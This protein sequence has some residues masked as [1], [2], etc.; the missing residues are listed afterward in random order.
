MAAASDAC[1]LQRMLSVG[2]RRQNI[3]SDACKSNCM[4]E[5][6]HAGSHRRSNV[7]VPDRLIGHSHSIRLGPTFSS[8][9][10]SAARCYG[11]R[12]LASF[13]W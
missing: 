3:A 10:T 4:S 7:L 13:R 9:S 2:K 5:C 11:L 8:V 6:P 1:Y 12:S